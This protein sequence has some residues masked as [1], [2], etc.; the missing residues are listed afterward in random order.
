M[1]SVYFVWY[2]F[3]RIRKTLRVTPA[4][5]SGLSDTLGDM[6]WLVGL[7][8]KRDPKPGPRGPYKKRQPEIS[9]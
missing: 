4:M 6:D 9:N 2:N 8:E 7:I 5:A 3:C 1:L